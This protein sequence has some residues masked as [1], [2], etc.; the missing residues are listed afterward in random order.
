MLEDYIRYDE[1]IDT[2]MRSVVKK[3][4]E[5]VARE[6]FPSN[7]HFLVSFTTGYEGVSLSLKLKEQYPSDMTI[8]LQHQYEDLIIEEDNFKISLRFNG[9]KETIVIPFLSITS[10]ADPSVKF[11]LKF[12]SI[13]ENSEDF[14]SSDIEEIEKIIEEEISNKEK[15]KPKTKAKKTS[16]IDKNVISLDFGKKK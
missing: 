4:L 5:K 3:A 9:T 11:G 15:D 14:D 2:A 8:V 12:N 1:L 16:K 7:H 6:G 13:I 10:F